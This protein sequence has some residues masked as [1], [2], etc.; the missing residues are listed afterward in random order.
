MSQKG[1]RKGAVKDL[2]A[3]ERAACRV[4]EKRG[5]EGWEAKSIPGLLL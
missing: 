3:R 1:K 4:R 2:L 5:K